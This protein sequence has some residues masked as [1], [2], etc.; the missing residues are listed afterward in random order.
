MPK[1]Q[2]NKKAKIAPM[3]GH[4]YMFYYFTNYLLDMNAIYS[5]SIQ[6]PSLFAFRS[7][8]KS[9]KLEEFAYIFMKK[10]DCT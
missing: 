8:L 2:F 10:Y 4:K 9:F 6:T 7:S 5:Q 1:L 3:Y